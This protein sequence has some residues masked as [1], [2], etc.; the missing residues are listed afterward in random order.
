M[1]YTRTFYNACPL[2]G[3]RN[4]T[5]LTVHDCR[6]HPLWRKELP[7]VIGWQTCAKCGHTFTD[8][9]FEGEAVEFLF[10][11]GQESQKVHVS[12]QERWIASQLID[13][14]ASPR[15]PFDSPSPTWLDVGFGSGS[16]VMTAE[17]YG[18]DSIGLDLRIENVDALI[19]LGYPASCQTI[20]EYAASLAEM[21]E[22]YN[23]ISMLD[24]LEHMPFPQTALKAARSLLTYDGSLIISCPNMDTA[25]WRDMDKRK[26]NP[27]WTE[28]E[29][30]HNFT[31][32][33][34]G[35]LLEAHGFLPI[36]YHVSPRYKSCMEIIAMKKEQAQ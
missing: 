4:V 13:K 16:L 21:E 36:S 18:Y 30:Y 24:V 11:K 23:V 34:M 20:E 12:E 15:E 29:H 19:S 10:A 32:K 33:S 8:G 1:E 31:M 17:E 7:H 26:A 35:L 6:H 25:I 2:C 27:Y 5:S 3:C 9:Y 28:I 14:V 22:F